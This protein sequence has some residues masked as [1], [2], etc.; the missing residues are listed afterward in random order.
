MVKTSGLAFAAKHRIGAGPVSGS[1]GRLQPRDG[2]Q[3]RL[4]SGQGQTR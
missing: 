1:V 2:F 3:A 4:W